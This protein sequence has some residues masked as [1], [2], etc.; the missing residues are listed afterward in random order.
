[1]G[2]DDL[3]NTYRAKHVAPY[4]V[5]FSVCTSSDEALYFQ[6]LL[7]CST[8]ETSI[9]CIAYVQGS[10]VRAMDLNSIS[11]IKCML[12]QM[13][14]TVPCEKFQMVMGTEKLQIKTKH[15][16]HVGNLHSVKC[17]GISLNQ[18]LCLQCIWASC[19]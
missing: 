9:H 2:E 5:A 13:D 19:S 6:K 18:K 17:C 10:V 15:K 8:S 7:L 16:V 4:V 12:V 14:A 1:M 3:P 11:D